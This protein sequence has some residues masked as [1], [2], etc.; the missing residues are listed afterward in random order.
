MNARIPSARMTHRFTGAALG[1]VLMGLLAVSS[2]A[3]CGDEKRGFTAESFGVL[4]G[5]DDGIVLANRVISVSAGGLEVGETGQVSAIRLINVGAGA[6]NIS[7]ISVQSEPAGAY[8][9]ALDSSGTP[10]SGFPMEIATQDQLEGRRSVEFVLLLTR[11]ASSVTPTGKLIVQSNARD[12]SGVA[13]PT[14]E[15]EIRLD[16]SRP[17]IQV[18]PT[19]INLGTVSQGESKQNNLNI[20]NQGNDDLEIDSFI[21]R[22]HPDLELVVG[23]TIYEVSAESASSGIVFDEP[24][25]VGVGQT[26]SMAIRYTANDANEAR[27]ELVLFSND[28]SASTGTVVPIQANVGGPC[29]TVNPSKVAFGGKLVGKAARVE[30]E[31]TS[32]GDT[33]LELTEI[34]LM[35]DGSP[36]YTL[37]LEGMPNAPVNPGQLGPSDTPIVLQP[38]AKAKFAVIYF[39]EDISPLDGT[40]QPIIDPGTIRIR[41]NSFRSE[42]LTE[43]T[44]FG[45]EKECPTAVIVVQEGEEVIPQTNL[46]LIGSQSYAAA[47]SIQ[48]YQ[49]EVDQ[50][51]GSR[52]VFRPSATIANPNFEANVAGTY[53]FRLNVKDSS[54]ETSCVPAQATVYVNPNEAI[55]IELLW[56][57][58][59][60][61]DQTNTGNN[62]G[63]DLDIHFTHP[64]AVGGYDGDNDGIMD[65]WYDIPYD[66]FWDNPEPNW[67][68]FDPAIGDNPSLDR[69]DTDGAGPENVNLNLPEN[70]V[71]YKI[72]VHYWD[73]HGFGP[74]FA[75][76][77]TYIYGVPVFEVSGIE[78]LHRDMWTVGE[79]AWPPVS[80]SPPQMIKVC[81]G[82]TRAC[83]ND[84]E[85]GAGKCGPRIAPNYNHPDYFQP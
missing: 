47:G 11:P 30:V 35:P 83:T 29:I 64:L 44:G 56:N 6:L 13:Q 72:G 79:V 34:M 24:L 82:T 46:H 48:S 8:A 55:H 10:L 74:S 45:V 38:N 80:G 15:F 49:W 36:E 5:Y 75:T 14:I 53:I 4:E 61:P 63:A 71:R 43:V 23:S 62:A 33:A 25:V 7:N 40:G 28:P 65:G 42:V 73:D 50:P 41:S 21:F 2:V 70:G 12:T 27:G 37:S 68:S 58:P 67:A 81:S 51:N 66:C 85:C 31:I 54:G 84:G 9:I 26:T 32:C 17:V 19:A 39:P 69:D 20:V 76:V 16:N 1:S 18:F 59:N 60:D 77:R 78:L 22:G 57:T 3:G 52:S